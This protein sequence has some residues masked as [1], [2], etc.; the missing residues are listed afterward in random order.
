MIED[1]ATLDKRPLRAPLRSPLVNPQR[2]LR[3]AGDHIEITVTI[4]IRRRGIGTE[5][6]RLR[7]RAESIVDAK[8]LRSENSVSAVTI[9]VGDL[10]V[11]RRVGETD[12]LPGE[13]LSRGR[14]DAIEVGTQTRR[15]SDRSSTENLEGITR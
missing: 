12:L 10:R 5:R 13:E 8:L 6:G 9:E 2:R 14:T 4:K 15:G 1:L 3:R 11:D 7:E